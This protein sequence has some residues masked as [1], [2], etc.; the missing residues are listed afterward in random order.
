MCSPRQS[1]VAALRA[2]GN[3]LDAAIAAAATIAVVYPHMNG[4]RWG[5]LLADPRC[6]TPSALRALRGAGAVG[7][8]GQRRVV[9]GARHRLARFP[10]RGG[11]AALTVPGAVDGWWQAHRVSSRGSMGSPLG[12][13][14]PAGRRRSSM[15]ARDSR[16]PTASGLPPP[17]EPDLFGPDASPEMQARISGP[18]TIP[19][20][21]P[22]G[23]LIQTDLARTIEAIRGG[24]S[25]GLLSRRRSGGGS[26]PPRRR[27]AARSRSRTS[28]THRSEWMEP[29]T[30]RYGGGVAASFPPPTQG[31]S[32]ADA[33]GAW[34][35]AFDLAALAGRPT[36]S[37]CW[38][39]RPS[40]PS[41][42]ATGT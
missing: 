9:R 27:R 30:I 25:R 29:L 20:R 37:T 34:S 31:L 2:G 41:P 28:P 33:A 1:G 36:T 23:R 12:W 40:S 5:Q 6:R 32:R 10:A 15:R 21:S 35:E 42:T 4:R 16:P 18:S 3:A 8:G 26:R 13:T 19:T 22:A 7:A 38:W 11:A 14:R 24:R 39:K 17:R